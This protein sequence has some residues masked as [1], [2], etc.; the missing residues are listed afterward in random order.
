DPDVV[1][2]K[3]GNKV[4][5]EG[6]YVEQF[7][8]SM[9]TSP[10]VTV[11]DPGTTLPFS[12]SVVTAAAVTDG[13]ASAEPLE[14]MLCEVDTVTVANMNPD[15]P[16]DFDE[17]QITDSSAANLRVDDYVFDPLD[18]TY[19]VGTAFSKVVGICGFSFNQRKLWPRSLADLAP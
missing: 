5:V 14:G 15:T 9:L 2:V 1:T 13:G 17:F 19:A 4:D 8:L 3:V 7:A 6:D 18:N 12:P 11:T 10:K 16:K